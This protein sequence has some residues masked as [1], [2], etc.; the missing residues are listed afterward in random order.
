MVLNTTRGPVEY[1]RSRPGH[2]TNT[3]RAV[4]E[5]MQYLDEEPEIVSVVPA[6]GWC[7][8]VGE[9][10]LPLVV[11]VA[12]D[13]GRMYGVVVGDDGKVDLEDNIE[14]AV[15]FNGYHQ[16]TNEPKEK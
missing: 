5:D 8:A 10:L 15:D 4:E 16:A 13:S 3:S 12:L 11:F 1:D 14:D 9:S 6:A 7:A 2:V